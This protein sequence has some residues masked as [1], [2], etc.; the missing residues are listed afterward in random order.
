MSFLTIPISIRKGALER[1]EGLAE[2]ITSNLSLLVSTPRY[3][4]AADPHFGFVFNNLKFENVNER[5][6]VVYDLKLSGSSKNVNTYA[7]ELQKAIVQYEPRLQNVKVSMTYI[8]EEKT[9]YT[10]VDAMI[11]ATQEPYQYTTTIKVW[12]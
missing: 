10:T 2:A 11:S 6:G 1:T 9:I 3:L 4:T 7:A 5:E 8:R 12:R